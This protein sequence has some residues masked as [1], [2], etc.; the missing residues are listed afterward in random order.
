MF[1]SLL[2]SAFLIALPV[3]V[4]A[5]DEPPLISVSPVSSTTPSSSLR[6]PVLLPDSPFYFLKTIYETFRYALAFTPRRRVSSNLFLAEERLREAQVMAEQGKELV[7]GH[8]LDDYEDRLEVAQDN[9]ERARSVGEGAVAVSQEVSQSWARQKSI[10][11]RMGVSVGVTDEISEELGKVT[12]V[13]ATLKRPVDWW[14]ELTGSLA[15]LFRVQR[16]PL[17]PVAQ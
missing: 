13:S 10:L 14:R 17:S 9:L 8:L 3:A 11:A 15:D 7:F 5:A 12:T 6:E 2:I 1:P 4:L 16:E